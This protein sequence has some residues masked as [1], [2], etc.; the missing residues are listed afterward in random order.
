MLDENFSLNSSRS[1]SLQSNGELSAADISRSVSPCS[2]PTNPFPK[3]NFSVADL[4]TTF[5]NQ[6]L[7][8]DAQI[9]NDSCEAY[10]STEDDAG[11]R[12]D[13]S[14]DEMDQHSRSRSRS[15]HTSRRLQRQFNTRLLCSGAHQNAISELI[16]RMVN[17][18]EQCAISQS[19]PTT[20]RDEMEGFATD[21]SNTDSSHWSNTIPRSRMS[22]SERKVSCAGIHKSTRFRHDHR[23]GRI[24]PSERKSS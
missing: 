12:L 4:T 13:S 2:I 14:S 5:A 6:R 18:E 9:W 21:G 1:Q 3:P 10:A 8:S 7:I 15:N 17:S 20:P 24:R 19:N 11:W 23:Y 16:A 22:S